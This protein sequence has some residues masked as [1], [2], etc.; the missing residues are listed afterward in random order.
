MARRYNEM[1][2]YNFETSSSTNGGVVQ[3]FTQL[4]WKSST[5]VGF[6]VSVASSPQWGR[7]GMKIVVIVAKFKPRGNVP[8]YH[9]NVMPLKGEYIYIT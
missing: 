1:N 4:V 5:K 2:D 9:A 7:Y 3:H 8:P 6:G